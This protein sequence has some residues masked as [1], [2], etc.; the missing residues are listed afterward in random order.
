MKFSPRKMF[1]ALLLAFLGTAAV[2]AD[3]VDIFYGPKGGFSRIN[4]SRALRFNDGTIKP[5]TLASALIHRIEK[6][7]PGSRVKIA[8]YSMNDFR[9]LDAMLK[10]ALEKQVE[11]QLLLDGVSSWSAGNRDKIAKAIK[12]T[13]EKAKEAGKPF[14]FNLAETTIEAMKR[15]GRETTLKDGTPIYGTM[16]EKFGVFYAP[17]NPIPHSSFNGSAN[18]STTSDQIYAENR[19]FFDNQPAVARQFAE[20]FA[21]LWNEYSRIVVGEWIP[22]KYIETHHVPGYVKIVFNSEPQNELELS[23]IDHELINLIHRVEASGSLELAMFSLTRIDLAEAILR[24]AERN[25]DAKFRLLLDHA[26]L[27]DEDPVQSKLAPWLEQQAKDRGIKNIQV[28]YR[29]RVNAYGYSERDGKPMLISYLSLFLHHKNVTVNRK[30]M[31]IGS[32]NWSNSAEFLNFE[33][34]MFFNHFCKDHQKVIDSFAYEFEELWNSRMP[35]GKASRPR[36]GVPQTV[37]LDEGK[38]LHTR[39]IKILEKKENHMVLATLDREAFKTYED[40]KSE[41][42]LAARKVKRALNTLQKAGFIVE[43]HKDGVTGFS[44][45]D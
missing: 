44:Q 1:L 22:E 5:A 38:A 15:N 12:E 4:N 43:W 20:E 39:L 17:E 23:R 32:Y 36:K 18:I 11:F 33:N 9:A 29:F 35:A 25:P 24:S 19:V 3:S 8:M 40:I 30:E 7:E 10:A 31:A 27:D 41:T 37:T 13:A 42:K 6:L 16:H 21:R 2:S 28:R 45:A 14:T 26:Q 34:V